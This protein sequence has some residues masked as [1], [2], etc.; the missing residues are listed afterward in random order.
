[1]KTDK[2][3]LFDIAAFGSA[4]DLSKALATV[5]SFNIDV[6]NDSGYTLAGEAASFGN[7]E[8]LELLTRLGADLNLCDLDA[9]GEPPFHC[10]LIHDHHECIR[11]LLH[12]NVKLD[13]VGWMGL[14]GLDRLLDYNCRHSRQFQVP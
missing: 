9:G 13:A 3:Y 10:A 5:Q 4:D 14:T 8:I 2:D 1:M 7:I 12:N 11:W 6:I